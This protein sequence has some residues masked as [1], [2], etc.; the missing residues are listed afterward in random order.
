M[1]EKNESINRFCERLKSMYSKEYMISR[2][3]QVSSMLPFATLTSSDKAEMDLVLAK[4]DFTPIAVFSFVNGSSDNHN[5]KE[6]SNEKHVPILLR[7]VK[8][9]ILDFNKTYEDSEIKALVEDGK[10]YLIELENTAKINSKEV[11]KKNVYIRALFQI[12]IILLICALGY[13]F[14]ANK[15]KEVKSNSTIG[16]LD[17]NFEFVK[18]KDREEQAI[19]AITEKIKQVNLEKCDSSAPENGSMFVYPDTVPVTGK[20]YWTLDNKTDTH[21]LVKISKPNDKKP[22][23]DIYIAPNKKFSFTTTP[24]DYIYNVKSIE[25]WCNSYVSNKLN[26]NF[27][28]VTD[29]L[30]PSFLSDTFV[31]S[32]IHFV[33]KNL[34]VLDEYKRF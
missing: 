2:N 15:H 33:G 32:D 22:L 19:K 20:A 17:P 13:L 12:S 9:F 1:I 26:Q 29:R 24:L 21:L 30:S 16:S 27:P 6:F 28:Y 14:I 8:V 4:K 18:Q 7:Y 23:V 34:T 5:D 3:V 10:S 25:V 31:T 11:K